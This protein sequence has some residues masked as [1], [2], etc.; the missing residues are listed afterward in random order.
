MILSRLRDLW[1]PRFVITDEFFP[2]PWLFYQLR[3][4][5]SQII[6]PTS[7]KVTKLDYEVPGILRFLLLVAREHVVLCSTSSCMNLDGLTRHLRPSIN[8]LPR[9][10]KSSSTGESFPK[11]EIWVEECRGNKLARISDVDQWERSIL[12]PW[13]RKHVRAII[14]LFCLCTSETLPIPLIT[15]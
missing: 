8:H 5:P 11:V 13:L 9:S 7:T 14:C 4:S 6:L 10:V 3:E 15:S 12:I 2:S 1:K